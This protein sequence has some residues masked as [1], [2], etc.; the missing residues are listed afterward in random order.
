V[1]TDWRA[2]RTPEHLIVVDLESTVHL[3]F[4]L[5]ADPLATENLAGM[6]A[7]QALQAALLGR[8]RAEAELSGDSEL[9]KG[10]H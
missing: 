10:G 1:P 2:L 7:A 6:P 9:L 8:L 5:R 3:L 4:D